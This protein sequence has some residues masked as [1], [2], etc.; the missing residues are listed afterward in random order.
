MFVKLTTSVNFT[1]IYDQLFCSNVL[2]EA[3]LYLWI[4]SLS[5]MNIVVKDTFKMSFKLT[6]VPSEEVIQLSRMEA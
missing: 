3:F 1:N 4:V 6:T 2:F 5:Q